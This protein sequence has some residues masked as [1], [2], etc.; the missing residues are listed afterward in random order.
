VDEFLG[1]LALDRTTKCFIQARAEFI[2]ML[3]TRAKEPMWLR[4]RFLLWL[5]R[6]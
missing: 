6:R 5:L 3:S 1:H 2:A 4:R